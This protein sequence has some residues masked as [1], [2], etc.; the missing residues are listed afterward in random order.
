MTIVFYRARLHTWDVVMRSC[1]I[2]SLVIALLLTSW[3][4]M[5]GQ[6]STR[7]REFYVAFLPNYH[8]GGDYAPDSLYLFI[9]ADEPTTGTITYTNNLG[10]TQTRSFSITNP[11][12]I[13]IHRVHY[14][15]YELFGYNNNGQFTT[16]NE[17]E[18]RSPRVFR[19]T[20]DK[21]VAVY[22]LNQAL[23][24][25]DATLVLPV[26]ALGT[27]YYVM[28]YP[29]DGVL[30]TNGTLNGQYTPSQ[31]VVVGIEDGTDVTIYPSA[32]TTE[33]GLQTKSLRLDRG[34][35]VLYQAE[36]SRTNL[37]YDLTGTRIVA[38]KKVAVFAGHQR[39]LVPVQM[40]GTLVSR[41]QLYEQMIPRSV[42]GTTYIVTPF[43]E[44]Q[45]V[46][47]QPQG[48]SDLYRVL[49]ADN[50]TEVKVNG[51]VV[52]LLQ[53]GQFYEAPLQQ[54]SLIETSQPVL[55]AQ[56]KRSFSSTSTLQMGDPFMMIIPPRRQYL[57]HYRFQSCQVQHPQGGNTYYEHYI[58]V[59][60]TPNNTR[61][62][63]LDGDTLTAEFKPVPNTCYVYA[64]V[65]VS[66]G[67]HTINSPR[68][69]GLYVYGYGYADSYGYVGGM[70]FLPDL[71]D[72]SVNAG[73]DRAVC[74]GDSVTL[75]VLGN[76]A[77]IR[78]T[79]AP[80]YP[81]V[82]IPCDTC[83][84]ITLVPRATTRL[85]LTGF[86]SL[87]CSVSDEVNIT[88]YG[89][90]QLR[91]RPDTVVCSDA[92]ITIIAEGSFQT[93]Q[94]LPTEGLSCSNCP[95]TMVTPQPGKEVVYTAIAR[96]VG[97]DHCE[98]R[99]SI[100]VRYAP[101]IS[102]KVPPLLYLCQG[103]S[104]TLTLDYGGTVRWSPSQGLSCSDCKVVTIRPARTTRYTITGDSAGCTTQA[105]VEVRVVPKPTLALP[106]DTTLCEGERLVVQ[107]TAQ[108]AERVTISPVEDVSCSNCF[109]PIFSP[110]RTRTYAITVQ[111]GTGASGCSVTDSLTIT[112]LP[113]PTI[114][115]EEHRAVC[116]GDTARVIAQVRGADTIWWE[117]TD[118]VVCPTC[119]TTAIIATQNG[120]YTL[121]A[122]T[123]QGCV[124]RSTLNVTVYKRPMLELLTSDTS[125]CEG[126][127]VRIA[128]ISNGTV[129]WDSAAS[130]SCYDCSET[131]LTATRSQRITVRSY[132]PEG[133][134]QERA[135]TVTVYPQPTISLPRVLQLC[136]GTSQRLRPNGLRPEYQYRWSPA[137]GLTCT[138]CAEPVASPRT[139]TTYVLTTTTSNGCV[140]VDTVSIEVIPCRVALRVRAQALVSSYY[141]CDSVA[142]V[143]TIEN[144]AA[145]SD[146]DFQIESIHA[147]I[148]RGEVSMLSQMLTEQGAQPSDDFISKLP[149]SI[150][151]GSRWLYV[152]SF[153]PK[154]GDVTVEIHIRSEAGD[155]TVVVEIG[156]SVQRLRAQLTPAVEAQHPLIPGAPIEYAIRL[157]AEQW[158]ILDLRQLQWEIHYPSDLLFYAGTFR[159]E[160]RDDLING[161]WSFD[162][163]ESPGVSGERV[164]TVRGTGRTPIA[165]KGVIVYVGM[166]TLLGTT[167]RI[168][169]SLVMTVPETVAPC[170]NAETSAEELIMQTCVKELRFVTIGQTTFRIRTIAPNPADDELTVVYEV[171][172]ETPLTIELLDGVGRTVRRLFEG[173]HRAGAYEL[174]THLSDLPAGIYWCRYRGGGQMFVLP[175]HIVR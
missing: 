107:I 14:R 96:N 36:F 64:N 69:F 167:Y 129:Q 89:K 149:R 54:A 35:A 144:P 3:G 175:V 62:I 51:R 22:A 150:S 73:P 76:A 46:T 33:S 32:P 170:V 56:F 120:V 83:L 60:T 52:A 11:Q 131:I 171:G 166:G 74:L 98:A 58:T 148:I 63:L 101:G 138:D 153:R 111:S 162:A 164:L 91:V 24:T 117:P 43:A 159:M 140:D 118:G 41:D 53:R 10:Q 143:A 45:G 48:A 106:P 165:Q 160:D 86:D 8:N 127:R 7:G 100:R 84:T 158:P 13:F 6:L 173:V 55:V 92:P 152:Y 93:I 95:Q 134:A 71:P 161:G 112:V 105:I 40:R 50:G 146:R 37:N 116:E 139:T 66:G 1:S 28:S 115:L 103:D 17:N 133:C 132:S 113:R 42:W 142:I 108:G 77:S 85:R 99:D 157:E 155:T 94:W 4:E 114:R 27:E 2:V 65:P 16:P 137:D 88:V 126:S 5:W 141:R 61:S 168:Q 163:N 128:A 29:S 109:Q 18:Q 172:F 79:V 97:S 102:G 59:V 125:V 44:P 25:S 75:T 81:A 12:Q 47:T 135:V 68:L 122:A 15:L 156:T 57:S 87:G 104:I 20:T 30:N 123:K 49:A 151:V 119:D 31:F 110:S 154:S 124:T 82:Q 145:E 90:P 26:T 136:M 21:D 38:T 147:R 23:T 121:N 67:A 174:N 34:Q 78:W 70:A 19:V 9:V 80:G 130:L 169:P 39:A 72:V